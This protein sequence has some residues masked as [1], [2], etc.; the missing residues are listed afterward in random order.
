[1]KYQKTEWDQARESI[2]VCPWLFMGLLI[3]MR[4]TTL[5]S[6][7]FMMRRTPSPT[8]QFMLKMASLSSRHLRM[9]M[10]GYLAL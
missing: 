10:V 6:R 3:I 1:M 4:M 2:T 7:K 9:S 8:R 5:P